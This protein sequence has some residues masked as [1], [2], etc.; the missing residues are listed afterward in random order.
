MN[1][2][3][4]VIWHVTK[5][6]IISETT[7]LFMSAAVLLMSFTALYHIFTRKEGYGKRMAWVGVAIRALMVVAFTVEFYHHASIYPLRSSSMFAKERT[8]DYL[9]YLL[10][11][12][13][14]VIVGLYNL[15]IIKTSKYRGFFH[16]FDIAMM[17]IPFLHIITLFLYE[18]YRVVTGHTTNVSELV[19]FLSVII[20]IALSMYLFFRLYW[21]QNMK[22]YFLFFGTAISPM[23]LL[24]LIGGTHLRYNP[25]FI[26]QLFVILLGLYEGTRKILLDF[27]KRKGFQ[28]EK[29][30]YVLALVPILLILV[31]NPVYN[32]W[33]LGANIG[34]YPVTEIF[35]K[36]T[37]IATLEQ[38]Q[39][40][41]RKA[42]G[43]QEATLV[44]NY[45]I[46]ENF[47]N[48]Y[49]FYTGPYTVEISSTEG[50]VIQMHRNAPYA[51][52]E[53]G[54]LLYEAE[55]K[56]RTL[57]WFE[58]IDL[59]YNPAENQ[60]EIQ[61][62]ED[63]Y[64]IRIR[65]QFS[66][67]SIEK[68][69][70]Q[71]RSTE[72]FWYKDGTLKYF[73]GGHNYFP[74]SS[75]AKKTL[76][77]LNVDKIVEDWYRIL[78]ETPPA[79]TVG[80]GGMFFPGSSYPFEIEMKNKDR[81]LVDKK[82]VIRSFSTEAGE[83]DNRYTGSYEEGMEIAQD[84][85]KKIYRNEVS[86]SYKASQETKETKMAGY[87]QFVNTMDEMNERAISITLDKRGKMVSFNE[88]M[89]RPWK[90]EGVK[91]DFPI[92][93]NAAIRAVRKNYK[94]F[95]IYNQRSMLAVVSDEKEL[96]RYHWMIVIFPYGKAEHH[97]Y[98]V[99]GY[100]GEIQEIYGYK[101]GVTGEQ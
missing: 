100:T 4:A 56:E 93:R 66:D 91:N 64:I 48:G 72:L 53:G 84:Y 29:Y 87:Y 46:H 2:I 23:V 69:D 19:L 6:R 49:R 58:Q 32:V 81:I 34:N 9:I 1:L 94:A 8:L 74:K 99:D 85:L 24:I 13:Y 83:A 55:I 61:K 17:S 18:S 86:S 45:R 11:Y 78:G 50:S 16:A 39:E 75:E 20:V 5:H 82:G 26:L 79:Y 3:Q 36:G 28:P 10:F 59:A 42:V 65:K 54:E 25:L 41:A 80:N 30:P 27:I 33:D 89:K 60:M 43:D 12:G 22:N 77:K 73:T 96:Y 37:P 15:F 21:K 38:A 51:L 52:P 67:G 98:F 71:W 97:V 62:Q 31:A 101:E 95:E 70:R 68:K 7:L 90:T 63:G 88:G 14:M 40:A 76:E 47:H 35:Q 44:L 57:A 92:S